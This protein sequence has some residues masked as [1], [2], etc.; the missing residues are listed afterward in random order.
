MDTLHKHTVGGSEHYVKILDERGHM[1]LFSNKQFVGSSSIIYDDNFKRSSA[2][3]YAWTASGLHNDCIGNPDKCKDGLSV[4]FWF[5]GMFRDH[6]AL[7][8][9]I[10]I[11]IC[12][13][14]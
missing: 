14:V 4:S 7:S 9:Q 8:A 6:K 11:F 3:E 10:T 5:K 12:N 2:N 13:E 1:D